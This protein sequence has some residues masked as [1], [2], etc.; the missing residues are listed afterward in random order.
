MLLQLTRLQQN[1]SFSLEVLGHPFELSNKASPFLQYCSRV[2]E[3]YV[4]H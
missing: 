3:L 4:L 1:L 2:A